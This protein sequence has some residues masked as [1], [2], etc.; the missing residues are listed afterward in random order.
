MAAS[1][2]ALA[3]V[4][5]ISRLFTPGDFGAAAL[6]VSIVT[7]ISVAS[8]LRY[9]HAVIL[10]NQK[11][12]AIDVAMLSLLILIVFVLMLT[13]FSV[14]TFILAADFLWIETL[15]VW[16]LVIPVGVCF[17]SISNVAVSLNTWFRNYRDIAMA[18]AGQAGMLAMSR[19]VFGLVR[20]STAAGL[21]A[22]LLFGYAM[23]VFLLVRRLRNRISL[24]SRKMSRHRLIDLSRRYKQFPK[25]SMPTA[26]LRSLGQNVPVFFLAYMFLPA[27][28]GFYAM[29]TRLMR[30]PI[31]LV[32]ESVRRTYLQKASELNNKEITLV[33]S[34]VK[35]TAALAV[36]GILIFS[37]LLLWGQELFAVVLGDQ[38]LEAGRYVSI[39][40]PWFFST[41]VQ[42]ASSVT[43]IVFQKQDQL[44]RIHA[45]STMAMLLALM[46][47]YRFGGS[48]EYTLMAL[49]GVGTFTNIL[50]FSQAM[51]LALQYPAAASARMSA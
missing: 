48:P 9:E 37:P 26:L 32:A 16:W 2:I 38:W 41:F 31:V 47:V 17:L 6:F 34:L 19:I 24:G 23:R 1:A 45:V 35:T 8:T 46:L 14:L 20:G 44:F 33:S 5:I 21:I 18:D 11:E 27:T 15:G 43:Y 49:S 42:S 30:F 51:R 13:I 40:T 4:P 12:E 36:M 25:Y 3:A 7:V 28:V 29:A 50:I 39:L 10:P 22:G